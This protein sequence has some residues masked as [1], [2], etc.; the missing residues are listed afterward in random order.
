MSDTLLVI[1]WIFLFTF[2]AFVDVLFHFADL[3]DSD[4]EF[5]FEAIDG[6]ESN[7]KRDVDSR[8][9]SDGR[10]RKSQQSIVTASSGKRNRFNCC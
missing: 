7:K 8:K 5:D 3:D 4:D 9:E 1:L 6:V 2:T 10:H